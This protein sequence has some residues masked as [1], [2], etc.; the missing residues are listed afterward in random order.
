MLLSINIFLLYINVGNTFKSAPMNKIKSSSASR[1]K[2][3][4]EYKNYSAINNT[5]KNQEKNLTE[6]ISKFQKIINYFSN[7]FSNST[8]P[9]DRYTPNFFHVNENSISMNMDMDMSYDNTH[10]MKKLEK[11]VKIK[12]EKNLKKNENENKIIPEFQKLGDR[13]ICKDKCMRRDSVLPMNNGMNENQ[14]DCDDTYSDNIN[15]SYKSDKYLRVHATQSNNRVND[16]EMQRSKEFDYDRSSGIKIDPLRPGLESGLALGL[17]LGL[18]EG[19]GLEPGEGVR[20]GLDGGLGLGTYIYCI[21]MSMCIYIDIYVN[22]NKYIYIHIYTSMFIHTHIGL[23]GGPGSGLGYGSITDNE[24]RVSRYSTAEYTYDDEHSFYCSNDNNGPSNNN[25]SAGPLSFSSIYPTSPPSHNTV[26]QDKNNENISSTEL[27]HLRSFLT[28]ADR[29]KVKT[30]TMIFR[31]IN[32][33][34][35]L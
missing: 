27:D 22:M 35:T 1:F 29:N 20:L 28:N 14:D 5:E 34:N 26:K 15:G 31:D 23:V 25:D 13:K 4:N 30:T 9:T 21:Y 8:S 7:F 18:D 33:I 16:I 32:D 24:R 10:D 19:M 11:K 6:K 2:N 12:E 17:G 3:I